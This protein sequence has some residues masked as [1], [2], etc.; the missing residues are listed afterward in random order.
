MD[1]RFV[2]SFVGDGKYGA[3]SPG[4]HVYPGIKTSKT[5]VGKAAYLQYIQKVLF[6]EHDSVLRSSHVCDIINLVNHASCAA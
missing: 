4:L 5:A 2:V 1:V 6:V 3:S